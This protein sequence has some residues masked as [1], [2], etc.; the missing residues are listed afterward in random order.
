MEAIKK[1]FFELIWVIGPEN[2][3]IDENVRLN[4]L[5]WKLRLKVK[6]D[7]SDADERECKQCWFDIEIQSTRRDWERD[8]SKI[9]WEA[10]E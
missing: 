2:V 10:N 6:F 1:F 3:R 9:G 4:L 8:K 7:Y 5:I